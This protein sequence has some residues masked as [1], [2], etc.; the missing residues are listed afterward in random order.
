[1]LINFLLSVVLCGAK[2]QQIIELRNTKMKIFTQSQ[3]NGAFFYAKS[4]F[5][6]KRRK[7]RKAVLFDGKGGKIT[8]FTYKV[9]ARLRMSKKSS[10]FAP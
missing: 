9:R 3:E 4:I 1:M 7:N 5:C 8:I 6:D 10:I 2:V